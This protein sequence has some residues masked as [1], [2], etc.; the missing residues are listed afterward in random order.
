MRLFEHK[1]IIMNCMATGLMLLSCEDKNP[2]ASVKSFNGNK[3]DFD[4]F[5]PQ[6]KQVNPV[7]VNLL[8]ERSIGPKN[9]MGGISSK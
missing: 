2:S 9:P 8:E 6:N 3:L 1:N 5:V 7:V 4:L